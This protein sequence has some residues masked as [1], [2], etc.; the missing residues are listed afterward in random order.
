MAMGQDEAD[1]DPLLK[2][3]GEFRQELTQWIDGRIASLREHDADHPS[4]TRA[5]DLDMG[6]RPAE[7]EEANLPSDSRNRLDLLARQLN[8][9]LRGS[10]AARAGKGVIGKYKGDRPSDR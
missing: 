5:D 6:P 10:E 9:R 2:A 8:D 7:P 3:I 1:G 4:S